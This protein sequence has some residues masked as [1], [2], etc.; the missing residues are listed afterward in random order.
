[1][2]RSRRLEVALPAFVMVG[3]SVLMG[4]VFMSPLIPSGAVSGFVAAIAAALVGVLL[5]VAASEATVPLRRR[6][7][8]SMREG[9]E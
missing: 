1:M 9:R 7:L 5:I 2:D 4:M 3:G 6:I 8:A